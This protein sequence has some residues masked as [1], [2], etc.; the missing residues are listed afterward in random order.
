MTW[1]QIAEKVYAFKTKRRASVHSGSRPLYA[2]A[3]SYPQN[4]LFCT[5]RGRKESER[6]GDQKEEA[7]ISSF[8]HLVCY[9]PSGQ[10]QPFCSLQHVCINLYARCVGACV[11]LPFIDSGSL[12]FFSFRQNEPSGYGMCLVV[13]QNVQKNSKSH[14]SRRAV[15]YMAFT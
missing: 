2:A 1:D 14:S 3:V 5:T 8:L 15:L 12:V 9:H 10:I 11:V 4:L 13:S 7:S 6:E